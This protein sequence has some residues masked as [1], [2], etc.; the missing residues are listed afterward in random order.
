M[1]PPAREGQNFRND[2]QSAIFPKNATHII[3]A[4]RE[5]GPE[6][7]KARPK[8]RIF[9]ELSELGGTPAWRAGTPQWFPLLSNP[10][11]V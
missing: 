5:R 7:M 10:E 8:I 2:K 4:G 9:V 11:R 3:K 1:R 6:L